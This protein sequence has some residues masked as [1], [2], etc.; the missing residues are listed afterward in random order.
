MLLYESLK[1]QN[2][3]AS[4][5]YFLYRPIRLLR[6]E[7]RTLRVFLLIRLSGGILATSSQTSYFQL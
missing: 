6:R 2:I 7:I 1:W 3:W 5:L 4:L